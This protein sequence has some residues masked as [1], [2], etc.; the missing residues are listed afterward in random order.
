ML[1]TKVIVTGCAG[2]IGSHLC[3]RLIEKGYYV[4]GIDNLT[5]GKLSFIKKLKLNKNFN[6]LKIDLLKNKKL[7]KYFKGNKIVFHLAANADVRNGFL[8]PKKDLEQN[9]LVTYNILEAM[10]KNS[11]KKII[12]SSTGSVYGEPKTFPTKENDFFPIQTSLYGSSKLACEGLIQAY[13]YGYGFQSIIFRFVS[14]MGSRYTHGHLFDFYKQLMYEKKKL[15]VLGNGLQK[16]SYLN[17]DDCIDAIFLALTKMNKNIEIYNLGTDNFITVKHSIKIILKILNLNPKIYYTGGKRG[18][19]GDSPKIYLDTKKIRKIG[20][21]PKKTIDDSIK[22]T[23]SF[24]NK[25]RWL[26]N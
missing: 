7:F 6:F 14:I 11:I 23:I 17:I 9:T 2:F 13:C 1:K 26:F 25:N 3:E 5:T 18:W 22:E 19:I 12:F 24:F 10:R 16:K 20:W 8:Y 4:T 21:K 15:K